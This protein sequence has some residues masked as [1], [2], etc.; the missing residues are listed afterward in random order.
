MASERQGSMT[1]GP[2]PDMVDLMRKMIAVA[3]IVGTPSIVVVLIVYGGSDPLVLYGYPGMLL[4]LAAF[5]WVLLR[6]P[7]WVLQF[8][9]ALVGLLIVYWLASMAARLLGPADVHGAWQ[10]LFP[11]TFLGLIMF[12]LMAFMVFPTR[13]AVVFASVIPV[14][15]ALIGL[16]CLLSRG[17][18]DLIL[19]LVRYEVYLVVIIVMLFILARAK[20]LAARSFVEAERATREAELMRDMAYRDALTGLA[21]RR[22][23]IEELERAVDGVGQEPVAVISF[24]LD[25]FKDINDRYG[26]AMGDEVLREVGRLATAELRATD[27]VGR[28]GGEEFLV[29]AIGPD[30]QWAGDLAERIRLAVEAGV[31]ET[32]GISVTASFGVTMVERGEVPRRVIERVDRLMYTAKSS[33]RNRVQASDVGLG[34]HTG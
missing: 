12:A 24:D 9:R 33:G 5:L 14:A 19:D 32:V 21:N 25:H 15:S 18:E 17:A 34:G 4:L 29:I 11:S 7:H 28:W 26:H 27:T 31:R 6:R 8:S 3:V 2:S 23:L 22:R 10:S 1:G 30:R 16:F 20:E 13:W